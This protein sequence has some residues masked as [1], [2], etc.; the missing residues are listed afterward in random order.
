MQTASTARGSFTSRLLAR[1]A[2]I[3]PA[4]GFACSVTTSLL[5]RAFD[6]RYRHELSYAVFFFVFILV[7]AHYN[8]RLKR[9]PVTFAALALAGVIAGAAMGHWAS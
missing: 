1:E 3:G 7:A 4:C 9:R 8:G 2:W 6:F 5:G